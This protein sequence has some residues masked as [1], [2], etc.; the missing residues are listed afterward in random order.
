MIDLQTANNRILVID[1]MPAIH[2][3]FRKVLGARGS[4]SAELDD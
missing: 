3:D 4:Q 1:D 2:D